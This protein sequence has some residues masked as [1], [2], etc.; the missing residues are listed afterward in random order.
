M[1]FFGKKKSILEE[2][3]LKKIKRNGIPRH[4]AIIMDGNGRWAKE[5]GLPRTIGHRAGVETIRNIVKTCSNIGVEY[6]TLY[7]FSTENWK[8]PKD[9]V[10]ALMSL[11]VEFLRKEVEEL[12]KNNV[13][14]NTIG[15]IEKLP[16]ICSLELKKACEKTRRNSG[17]KLVLALNYG[18]R[19]EIKRAIIG[20]SNDVKLGNINISDIDEKL[21]SNY[22]YTSVIPDPDLLI[23]PS[24]EYRVSNFLLWQ[25]AYSEFWFSDIYWP[26]FKPYHLYKAIL[27]YQNRDRRFGGIK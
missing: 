5:R 7:A 24:G 21:I 10:N 13:S 3:M 11:L 4:I 9:E 26:D 1:F 22:M 19:D 2:E 23:R 20:I 18:S 27:D 14:I 6:L 12:N 17:L 8:R 16:E 15:D 25:I